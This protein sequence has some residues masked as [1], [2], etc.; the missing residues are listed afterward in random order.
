MRRILPPSHTGFAGIRKDGY[1]YA[2][3]TALIHKPVAAPARFFPGPPPALRGAKR[4]LDVQTVKGSVHDFKAYKDTHRDF[5][6]PLHSDRLGRG[7]QRLQPLHPNCRI[8]KRRIKTICW[9]KVTSTTN[10]LRGS[11][12]SSNTSTS[13]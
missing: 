13:K 6:K 3:K 10:G 9:P 7:C 1:C 12:L 11:G 4:I 2:D 5:C 8:A